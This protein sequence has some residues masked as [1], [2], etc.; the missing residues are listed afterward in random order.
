MYLKRYCSP[1]KRN[2]VFDLPPVCVRQQKNQERNLNLFC[3]TENFPGNVEPRLWL[4]T[5]I[6]VFYKRDTTDFHCH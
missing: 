4:E 1:D 5:E 3:G 2:A 6:G